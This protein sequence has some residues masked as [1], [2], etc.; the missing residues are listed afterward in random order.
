MPFVVAAVNVAIPTIGYEFAVEA[1]VTAWITTIFFL[2]VAV[3]QVPFGRLADI[4]GRKRLMIIGLSIA[5]FA[6]C[7][8]A[9]TGSVAMLL[10]SLALMGVGSGIMFNNSISILTS[11]FPAEMRGRALGISTGGTYVALSL[12]PYIGGAL[13][14][15]FGWKSIFILSGVMAAVVLLLLPYA[16]KG[17]WRE[18]KGEKFDLAGSVT[19]AISIACFIYGFSSLPDVPGIIL[20]AIG[21]AGFLIF[22]RWE[23]RVESPI[24]DLGLFRRNRVFLFSCLAVFVS[25][26]AVFAISFILNLYLQYVKGLSPQTAG[27]VMIVASALMA[28]MTPIS[29]RISDRIEPRFLASL[30]MALCCLALLLLVFLNENTPLWY[31]IVTLIINGFGI[32]IFAAPNT[33][34]I[35]GSIERKYLGVAAGTQGTMRTSGMMVSMGIIMI[36]FSLYIGDEQISSNLPAF[37]RSAQTGFIIFAVLSFVSIFIQFAARHAGGNV[38]PGQRK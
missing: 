32:G 7:I 26:I 11:V 25:Y 19:Y 33:N 24:F 38:P 5:I 13:T 36:I 16:L 8:G 9:L 2:A 21:V 20:F 34:A 37:L 23:A 35:M 22:A 4:Y 30:G 28:V 3:V 27:L 14:E 12:G 6:S 15:A 31:V 1:R 18:A 29:G 10:V 17:E